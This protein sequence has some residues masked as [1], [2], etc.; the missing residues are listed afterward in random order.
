MVD[1]KNKGNTL[2]ILFYVPGETNSIN[3]GIG[4]LISYLRENGQNHLFIYKDNI[5]TPGEGLDIIKE[6]NPDIVA[7]SSTTRDYAHSCEISNYIKENFDT[8]IFL[9]GAHISASP[10]TLPS[11][12]DVGFI[13]E[14]EKSML[15]V[16]ESLQNG[17][18]LKSNISRIPNIVYYDDL[19]IVITQSEPPV[20][21]IDEIPSP[22][23]DIYPRVTDTNGI[24]HLITSRG[25]PYNCSFCQ[26]KI[27]SGNVRMHSAKR[28]AEEMKDLY[29]N[30]NA[31][32]F[33]INDDLFIVDRKRLKELANLII[34]EGIQNKVGLFVNGRANLIDDDLIL[35][36]KQLNCSIVGMGLESMSQNVLSQLKDGVTVEDNIRAV[37]ILNKNNIK[38]GGLFI[39]GT[40]FEKLEDLEKTYDYLRK[41]RSKFENSVLSIATPLPKTKL[42]EICHQSGKFP[43]DVYEASF[44]K[45]LIASNEAN[46]NIYVGGIDRIQFQQYFMLF[47]YLLHSSENKLDVNDFPDSLE[48]NGRNVVKNYLDIST[49]KTFFEQVRGGYPIERWNEGNIFWTNGSTIA[50]IYL[51]HD[52]N[53]KWVYLKFYT[54]IPKMTVEFKYFD[55]ERQRLIGKKEL[56]LNDIGWFT[57]ILPLAFFVGAQ[58]IG[59]LSIKSSY[60]CLFDFGLSSDRRNL[61]IAITEVRLCKNLHNITKK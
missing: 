41:N 12:I 60:I 51:R 10:E 24:A 3:L 2:K 45:L 52:G 38:V 22:A 43:D 27:L 42:W 29:Y 57:V 14:A 49:N 7:I 16:F 54:I 46:K 15:S 50:D 55:L 33:H 23:W 25:C 28:I 4:Y 20:Q 19:N 48:I 53:E 26:A 6:V 8:L 61:G 9:G 11:S 5:I 17:K 34:S 58:K 18:L 59:K 39:I 13:G 35:L 1:V 47:I 31:R 56:H 32:I 40:P 44:N 36:L 30:Y 37:E 21:N